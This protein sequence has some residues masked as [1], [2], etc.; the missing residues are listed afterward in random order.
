[1]EVGDEGGEARNKNMLL[2]ACFASVA[3]VDGYGLAKVFRRL[4]GLLGMLSRPMKSTLSA[5]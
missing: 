2:Q 1:M 4:V 5:S 3:K